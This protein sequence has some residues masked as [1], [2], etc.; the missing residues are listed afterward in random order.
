M[1]HIYHTEAIILGSKNYGDSGKV[2]FLFTR[3]LGM[4]SAG[5]TGIRTMSSRLRYILQD[6]AY[7][8]VD[9]V[10][11]KDMWRLTSASKTEENLNFHTNLP[12]LKVFVNISR[13][14]RRLLAGEDVNRSLF[15]DLLKSLFV[16]SETNTKGE[17][18]NIEVMIV[19]RMLNHLGYIGNDKEITDLIV[20]PFESGAILEI[21]KNRSK[22][23]REINK[24]LRETQ[25]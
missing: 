12:A 22:I 10:R 18:P 7:V 23:L 9:L 20:S 6:Y 15:D 8:K 24:A 11:G 5:A 4:I 3:E 17:L 1:H 19:L 25:M 21:S 16:L 2:F 13:L 14:L